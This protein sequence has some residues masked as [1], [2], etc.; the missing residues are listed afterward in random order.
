MRGS[1]GTSLRSLNPTLFSYG[2][3]LASAALACS[4]SAP[5]SRA[6]NRSNPSSSGSIGQL[7]RPSGCRTSMT[8]RLC[9]WP[10][11]KSTGSWAGVTFRTP[12][13]NSGSIASSAMMGI[14]SRASGRQ[15]CFPKRSR[16]RLSPGWKAIAVSAMIV[17]GLVVATSRKRPG[18]STTSYRTK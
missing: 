8:G 11:S 9:R 6:S 1:I 5:L 12:V 13:P 4:S 10:I 2:S 3:V 18:S 14:F 7:I 15:A 17:S 16:Y